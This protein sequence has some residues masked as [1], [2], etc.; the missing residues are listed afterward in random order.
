M[1]GLLEFSI[2]DDPIAQQLRAELAA[3]EAIF[4]RQLASDMPAVISRL[5]RM[6]RPEKA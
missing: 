4:D 1:S 5:A 3:V 6:A 2:S